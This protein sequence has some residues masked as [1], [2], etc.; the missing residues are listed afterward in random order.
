MSLYDFDAGKPK[1]TRKRAITPTNGT[2]PAKKTPATKRAVSSQ[3]ARLKITVQ[4]PGQLDALAR[5]LGLSKAAVL[6]LAL[7]ELAARYNVR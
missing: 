3:A 5:K 2:T 4:H 1:T 7:S 6:N